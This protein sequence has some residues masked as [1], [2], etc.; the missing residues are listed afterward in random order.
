MEEE[1]GG[2]IS[3]IPSCIRSAR[4][5]GH[6]FR[7]RWDLFSKILSA[8][9][10][11]FPSYIFYSPTIL[12]E[13]FSYNAGFGIFHPSEELP[14]YLFP[15][16]SHAPLTEVL[17]SFRD[18]DRHS[19]IPLLQNTASGSPFHCTPAGFLFPRSWLRSD[20]PASGRSLPKKY[21]FKRFF[22]APLLRMTER[23]KAAPRNDSAGEKPLLRMTAF[24]LLSF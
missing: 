17:C 24:P 10:S 7:I 2:R 8:A 1:S 16:G 12:A 22:V 11:H 20:G 19:Q 9:L 4:F 15:Y 23:G 5:P 14:L 21:R 18:R 3:L 13:T 6:I